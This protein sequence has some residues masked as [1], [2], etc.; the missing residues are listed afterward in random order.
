[1]A[2]LNIALFV[3]RDKKQALVVAE[4]VNEWFQRRRIQVWCDLKVESL[5]HTQPLTLTTN[6]KS[7]KLAIAIGGDG[8]YLHAVRALKGLPVPVLGIN[9]GHLGFLTE[10]SEQDVFKTLDRFLKLKI[11][12][13]S[14]SM[15]QV[16]VKK[17]G[18]TIKNF[19]AL[20]DVVVERGSNTHLIDLSVFADQSL[21]SRVRADGLIVSTPTGST[22]YNLSAG[23]PILHPEVAAVVVTPVCPHSLT[24]RPVTFSDH[25][26]IQISL[27]QKQEALL[28]VDGQHGCDLTQDCT[29]IVTR[30]DKKHYKI[31][32]QRD[33]FEL[34]NS[35]LEFGHRT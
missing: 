20:N 28:M 10:T 13:I 16:S 9:L 17:R 23:G 26:K 25:H 15:L 1:M 27:N 18:K 24:S 5:K 32:S 14:R 8:T 4:K 34:L 19:L 31:E 22:A 11:K 2:K 7:M 29:V 35:K 3:R 33:Y 6:L 12:P 30:S 21:V